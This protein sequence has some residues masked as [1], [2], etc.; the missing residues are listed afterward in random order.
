MA[1]AVGI[2]AFA[3]SAAAGVTLAQAPPGGAAP[4][5][6][7]SAPTAAAAPA[8]LAELALRADADE[9][10]VARVEGEAAETDRSQELSTRLDSISASVDAMI[11]AYPPRELRKMPVMRLESMARH[12]RFD[13]SRFE[14][15]Q[16][17]LKRVGGLCWKMRPRSA[18]AASTGKRSASALPAANCPRSWPAG[19]TA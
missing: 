11:K 4:A 18:S 15:W 2:L 14:D 9:Q 8:T 17:E 7:A 1:R 13:R 3:F 19:S 12:W 6:A 10:L 5:D 16:A